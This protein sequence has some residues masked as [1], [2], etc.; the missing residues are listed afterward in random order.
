MRMLILITAIVF[1]SILIQAQTD[2]EIVNS[3]IGKP[4]SDFEQTLDK[5]G[6]KY[7]ITDKE[8]GSVIFYIQKETSIRKWKIEYGD[9]YRTHGVR[10]SEVTVLA[11]KDLISKIF[12]RYRHSNI[13]DLTE[14]FEYEVPEDTK[15]RKYEKSFGKDV[16][17]LIVTQE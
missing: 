5:T 3:L 12:I 9:L 10:E 17:H 13:G 8:E 2:I 1:G 14:F 16:S 6:F 7:Y 15:Y 11:G 4:Y